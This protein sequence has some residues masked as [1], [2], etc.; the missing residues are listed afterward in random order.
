M[1]TRCAVNI[2]TDR[3]KAHVIRNEYLY[4]KQEVKEQA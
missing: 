4:V 3:V 2:V 1:A